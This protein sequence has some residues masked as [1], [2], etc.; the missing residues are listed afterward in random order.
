MVRLQFEG[1][2]EPTRAAFI[3]SY[4]IAKKVVTKKKRKLDPDDPEFDSEVEYGQESDGS[5]E[6]S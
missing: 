2:K 6:D 4:G 1:L 5:E 3:N